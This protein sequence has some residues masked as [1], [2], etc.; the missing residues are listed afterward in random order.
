M[1]K[2]GRLSIGGVYC[3]L[4]TE[5]RLEKDKW[6]CEVIDRIGHIDGVVTAEARL[7]WRCVRISL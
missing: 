2:L 6:L 7:H 5:K 4:S 1:Q 3:I